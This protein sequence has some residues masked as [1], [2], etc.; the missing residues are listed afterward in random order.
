VSAFDPQLFSSVEECAEALTKGQ[1]LAK[2]TSLDVAQWLDD[3]SAAALRNQALAVGRAPDKNAPEFRRLVADVA[4]QAGTGRFFAYKLRSAVLWSIY[5]RTGDRTAV[6]EALKAYKTARQAWAEMAT[7]AKTV[8]APDITYGLNANMRGH[9][10]DRLTGI[11]ADLGDMEKRLNEPAQPKSVDPAVARRAI[12]T[13]LARPQ[14]PALSGHHTPSPNFDPGKPLELSVS[15]GSGDGRKVNLLY[16]RA[17][18][19]QRWQSKEMETRDRQYRSVI[20]GDYAQSPYPLLYY[21]EVHEAG[22]SG[23]YPGFNPDLS[24]QPYY[25]VRSNRPRG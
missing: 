23:I 25:L 2:Y 15:F 6:T 3:M 9:W 14:R 5:Q 20:P 18:Q 13:V 21:F 10:F 17:D 22:G 16:R 7:M 4:I 8:Y 24:N 19:S 12:A 1:S 11:D